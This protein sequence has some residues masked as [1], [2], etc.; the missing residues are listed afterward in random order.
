MKN[1]GVKKLEVRP[2]DLGGPGLHIVD[3]NGKQVAW[4]FDQTREG[5]ETLL[6]ELF[7]KTVNSYGETSDG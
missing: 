1:L 7:V 4:F 6:A 3:E 5:R 2:N